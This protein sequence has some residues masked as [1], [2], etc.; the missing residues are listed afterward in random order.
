MN[1]MLGALAALSL[2]A[3]GAQAQYGAGAASQPRKGAASAPAAPASANQAG[4]DPAKAGEPSKG[5]PK[6]MKKTEA[7]SNSSQ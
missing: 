1:K 5:P 6:Q 4:I 7:Q 2:L 3:A